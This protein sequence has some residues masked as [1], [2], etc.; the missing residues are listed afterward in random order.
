MPLALAS[1]SRRGDRGLPGDRHRQRVPRYACRSPSM[2]W[3]TADGASAGWASMRP[4]SSSL[5]SSASAAF[6]D[7]GRWPDAKTGDII[8]CMSLAPLLHHLQRLSAGQPLAALFI[9]YGHLRSTTGETLQAVRAH[10]PEHPLC[11]PGEADLTAQVDFENFAEVATAFGLAVDGP[12]TQAQF[13][14]TLGIV[15]RASRLMSANPATAAEIEAGVARLLSPQGM[16]TRFKVIG[17]RS[18][19]TAAAAGTRRAGNRAGRQMVVP[20]LPVAFCCLMTCHCRSPMTNSADRRLP[21]PARHPPRLLHAPGRR[22][23]GH[24]CLAQLRPWLE[25]RHGQGRGKPPAG[26]CSARCRRRRERVAH[27]LPGPQCDGA[28]G[29]PAGRRATHCPRPMPW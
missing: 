15:E 26:R 9:D 3:T 19:G 23:G 12:V 10:R 29:R 5:S 8:E 20:L 2:S 27:A 22:V 11:S 4:A 17:L 18:P 7:Q 1:R 28:G 21:R 24:L 6:D 25:R 16:G 14:G 13:L